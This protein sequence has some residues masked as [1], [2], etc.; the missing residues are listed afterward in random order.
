MA[1]S[2]DSSFVRQGRLIANE[3]IAACSRW[4]FASMGGDAS[5]EG[6]AEASVLD[7]EAMRAAQAHSHEQGFAA[8]R[9]AG[10]AE[11]QALFEQHLA[12][13]AQETAQRLANLVVNAEIGL[14]ASQ[15]DIARGTLEIA[16][17]LARQ[18][19]RHELAVGTD[20]L[21][22]VLREAL[23]MLMV[24]S[25][26]ARVRLSPIDFETL[27][28]A[29]S[30]ELASQSVTVV[31]DRQL[32]AGDCLVESQGV[33]IDGTVAT[34]WSRAVAGLGLAMPWEETVDAA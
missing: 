23:A 25:K 3:N 9:A 26:S 6:D 11:A 15:Q 19:L 22:S 30:T 18:V 21:Q 34:R 24:D 20:A 27:G 10:L 5:A 14:A 29:L 17:A 7:A 13:Q 16:C 33:T 4:K 28:E 8:G 32:T 2:S 12:A 1:A 31:V